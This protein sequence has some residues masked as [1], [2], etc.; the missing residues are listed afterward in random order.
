MPKDFFRIDN[1]TGTIYTIA[2]LDRERKD[3]YDFTVRA[4]GKDNPRVVSRPNCAPECK[5]PS[6][7]RVIVS[8]TDKDDQAPD[9]GVSTLNACKCGSLH[10]L[11][12]FQI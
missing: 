3:V 12:P 11:N 8:V 5:D 1:V 7:V 10:F 4:L 2:S 6:V 9:F